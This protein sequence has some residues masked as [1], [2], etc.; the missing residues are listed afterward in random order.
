MDL[1]PKGRRLVQG[2]VVLVALAGLML[3]FLW[4]FQR[5]LIY[6]PIPGHVPRAASVLPS[7]QDVTFS[8]TDGV[9]LHGWFVPASGTRA[10]A[11]EPQP[12]V[13]VFNGNAGNRAHRAP[14]AAALSGRG[15]SVLLF[16]YRGYG[17]NE[18]RPTEEGL[19][20]DAL[21][22][23]RYLATRPDVDPDRVVY[24]GESLGAAVAVSIAGDIPAVA[25]VLRSPFTS[26]ADVAHVHYPYLPARL[27]LR[28]RYPS[29]GRI[30]EIDA[31]V[32]VMATPDDEVV[33]FE[34]SRRLYEAAREPKHLAAIPSLGHNDPDM[35]AGD[36][37]VGEVA[38]FLATVDPSLA[39]SGR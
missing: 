18:G 25:I 13:V 14:L 2:L 38:R 22:A 10:S 31:P 39:P 34:L 11:T 29:L 28:D 9:T 4:V 23:R 21:A 8:T 7:A 15:L 30:G 26:L 37:L 16:D 5:R 1:L 6:I 33:P 20:A 32:L 12:A 3:A 36:R 35:L 19:R 17:G 27:L 24:F